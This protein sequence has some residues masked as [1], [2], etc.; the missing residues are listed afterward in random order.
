MVRT[1]GRRTARPNAW[2]RTAGLAGSEER[3]RIVEGLGR[4]V[5]FYPRRCTRVSV[6]DLLEVIRRN[7]TRADGRSLTLSGSA[8]LERS[9]TRAPRA[10]RVSSRVKS[11]LGARTSSRESSTGDL[12]RFKPGS[13]PTARAEVAEWLMRQTAV[14]FLGVRFPPRL[15]CSRTD[16]PW[17]PRRVAWDAPRS[18]ASWGNSLFFAP[19]HAPPR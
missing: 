14:C 13:V 6:D 2:R 16:R 10:S 18:D 7:R 19:P 5:Q 4:E 3:P 12:E 17:R 11:V 9:K 15:W 1:R 8:P